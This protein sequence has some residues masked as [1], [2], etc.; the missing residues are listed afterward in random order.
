MANEKENKELL[1]YDGKN[2]VVVKNEKDALTAE[3]IKAL[4]NKGVKKA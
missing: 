1:G 2:L 3:Q 4:E